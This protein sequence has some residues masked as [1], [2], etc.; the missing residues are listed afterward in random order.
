MISQLLL[1]F[2]LTNNDRARANLA[3]LQTYPQMAQMAGVRA[4]YLYDTGQ[5]SHLGWKNSFVNL[6]CDYIGEN[7]AKNYPSAISEEKALM[8]SPT[9]RANILR[10]NYTNMSIGIYKNITVELFCEKN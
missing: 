2:M 7:L 9:H 6:D 4:K 8:D 10:P 1:L 3:P 5:W